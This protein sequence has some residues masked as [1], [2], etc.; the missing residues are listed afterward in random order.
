MKLRI[1]FRLVI[2]PAT[3]YL[4]GMPLASAPHVKS[5]ILHRFGCTYVGGS[6][7]PRFFPVLFDNDE[8]ETRD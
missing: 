4:T 6:Y 8:R 2:I 3:M 7:F 1:P 5:F